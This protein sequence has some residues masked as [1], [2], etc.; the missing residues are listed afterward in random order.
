MKTNVAYNL[1]QKRKIHDALRDT[2]NTFVAGNSWYHKHSNTN[3]A[4]A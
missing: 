1:S 4:T 2:D 3:A